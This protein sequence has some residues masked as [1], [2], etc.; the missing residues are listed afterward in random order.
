MSVCSVRRDPFRGWDACYLE[1]AYVR[2]VAV[3]DIGG[4][5]MAYDLGPYSF[6][7]VAPDLAGKL[8]TPEENQGDGSLAAWKNYGGDKTWP[9]PQGWDN[10]QQW[11]GPPDPVLDT[12]RYTL[13]KLAVEDG[14]AVVVMT[15]P[16]DPRTGVQITRQITLSPNSSR[17]R[18]ELTFANS[19]DHS[20]T[21]GI[22]DVVQLRAEREQSD[23]H[24]THEPA[25]SVTTPVNP[26]SVFPRGFNIM[27]GA[28]DNSQWQIDPTTGLFTAPYHWEIGKVGLDSSAGWV[29]FNNA[30]SGYSFVEQFTYQP[31]ADYPDGGATVEV[32]TVGAGQVGNFDFEAN[33]SYQMETEILG[34]LTS[35]APGE[36]TAFSLDWGACRGTK[37]VIDV[38]EAGCLSAP[39]ELEM[40]EDGY[41]R[42]TM[43][44]GVFDPGD[45]Q[46]VLLDEQHNPIVTQSLGSVDPLSTIMLDRIVKIPA[47]AVLIDLRLTISNRHLSLAQLA[48]GDHK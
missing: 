18:L 41:G 27:F 6:F 44:G 42:I 34:P 31:G 21:W 19:T 29:A 12:G 35:I 46:L 16:S 15:S 40:L 38:T 23:G 13:D 43:S 39:L 3:P 9:A 37:P 1:N 17:V 33:P 10:D 11:H 14:H 25:C 24:L 36:K 45:L 30:K 20:L 5:I 22:W 4:R 48:L 32:W 47:Q 2:L 8:F 7:F 28:A 26:A